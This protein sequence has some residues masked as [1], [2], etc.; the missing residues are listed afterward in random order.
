ME[1]LVLYLDYEDN[2]SNSIELPF[3]EDEFFLEYHFTQGIKEAYFKKSY[4]AML[5]IGYFNTLNISKKQILYNFYIECVKDKN[6]QNIKI[7]Y[8]E[9]ENKTLIEDDG[10]E[11][12]K[13]FVVKNEDVFDAKQMNLTCALVYYRDRIA[14]NVT[15][16]KKNGQQIIFLFNPLE[17]ID[18]GQ[19]EWSL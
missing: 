18:M 16:D 3:S 17:N 14:N 8:L 2:S 15:K 6:I 11:I 7:K 1:K 5:E 4:E 9:T 19:K 12:I 13:T 10:K